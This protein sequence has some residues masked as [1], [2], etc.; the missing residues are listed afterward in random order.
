VTT[1][2]CDVVVVGSTLGALVTGAYAARAGLRVALVEED[3]QSKRPPI[4]REPFLISRGAP[5]APLELLLRELGTS[6]IDRRRLEVHHPAVQVVLPDARIDMGGGI[7]QLAEEFEAY[8]LAKRAEARGWLMALEARGEAARAA[9]GPAPP[10]RRNPGL[11]ER[12][13]RGSPPAGPPEGA[14][15]AA[16]PAPGSRRSSCGPPWTARSGA[17]TPDGGFWPSCVN[18]WW[19]FTERCEAPPHLPSWPSDGS[20]GWTSDG[21]A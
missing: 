6:P 13:R 5:P 3:A 11:R 4:L 18:A 14:T 2:A 12:L 17:R 16:P 7:D 9:F 15:A 8:G 1:I 19:R 21:S 20:S 10:L